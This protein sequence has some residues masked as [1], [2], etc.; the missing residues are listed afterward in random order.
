MKELQQKFKM[1]VEE[2]LARKKRESAAAMKKRRMTIGS[3][4]MFSKY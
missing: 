3:N 1:P 4:E 2:I